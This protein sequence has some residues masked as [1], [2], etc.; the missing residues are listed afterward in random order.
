MTLSAPTPYK[1]SVLQ[2]SAAKIRDNN[3]SAYNTLAQSPM[4]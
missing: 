1:K 3:C 2:L 4:T